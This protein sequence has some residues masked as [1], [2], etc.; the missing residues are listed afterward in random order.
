MHLKDM[1][2]FPAG[3]TPACGFAADYLQKAGIP[4]VDHPTP[5]VTH[6]MLDVPSFAPDGNLRGG[7]HPKTILERLPASVTVIGGN[8]THPALGGYA[9]MDL[10]LDTQYLT[11]NAAITADCALRVAAPHMTTVFTEIPVCIIGWGRIGK[12]LGALLKQVGADVTIAARKESDRAMIQALGAKAVDIG[13]I[14]GLL[15][16]CRLLYNTVPEIVVPR[17]AFARCKNC[18]KIELASAPGLQ[19]DDVLSAK[20]LPGAYAPESSGE[21]I[22]KT[23]LRLARE[24]LT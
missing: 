23:I 7:S 22:A 16:G 9:T 18:V 21:L 3:T 17:H 13:D 14:P 4:L 12:C 19:G 11:E 20:G 24:G 2:I 10:L 15:P 6:L 1:L 8:L 5:E